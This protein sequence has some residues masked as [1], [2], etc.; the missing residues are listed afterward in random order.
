M[1]NHQEAIDLA[2][3][4][5]GNDNMYSVQP[6]IKIAGDTLLGLFLE[7]VVYWSDK[8]GNENLRRDRIFYKSAEEWQ[9]ELGLSYA[10]VTR[11]RKEL[12][13]MGFIETSKHKVNN[14]PTI[15]YYANMDAIKDM[16]KKRAP[17]GALSFSEGS[18]LV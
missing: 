10:Q 14:A 8:S 9:D 11:A 13:D 15:H 1:S 18:T 17:T 16:N 12:Q 6:F 3:N 2:K 4:L 5:A 7:R